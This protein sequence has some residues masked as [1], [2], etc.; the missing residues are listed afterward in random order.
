[1]IERDGGTIVSGVT[2]DIGVIGGT[3]I[4]IGKI[5]AHTKDDYAE[6]K[7]KKFS[8]IVE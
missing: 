5:T 7:G 3:G 2:I 8:H 1:M 6:E 4:G